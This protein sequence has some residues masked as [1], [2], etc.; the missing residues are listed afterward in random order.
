ME[1][2]S[3]E[4]LRQ[5]IAEQVEI[6]RRTDKFIVS[7]GSPITPL[8]PLA[9]IRRYIELGWELGSVPRQQEKLT[10]AVPTG[11]VVRRFELWA[12]SL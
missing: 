4:C 10:Q 5:A 9:R 3:D 11:P 6:G 8:A 1:E 7:T 12:E 2:G